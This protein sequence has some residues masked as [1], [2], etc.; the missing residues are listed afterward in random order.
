M[1]TLATLTAGQAFM[2]VGQVT[3]IDTAGT[4][5]SLFGPASAAGG[6]ALIAPDG[7]MTGNLTSPANQIPVQVVTQFAVVSAGDVLSSDATGETLV[8]RKVAVTP[9]G[10]YQWSASPAGGVTYKTDGWTI[11]GHIDL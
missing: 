1:T 4:H 7:T 5:L 3:A 9:D 11:I 10:S 2:F 8:A 6:T